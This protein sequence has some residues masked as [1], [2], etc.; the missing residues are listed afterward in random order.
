MAKLTK[1]QLK[2]IIKE[3]LDGIVK[4][5][6]IGGW[7]T[8]NVGLYERHK[9]EVEYHA[10]HIQKK[11]EDFDPDEFNVGKKVERLVQYIGEEI[12]KLRAR[13]EKATGGHAGA[14]SSSQI[15]E[16][17]AMLGGGSGDW[18]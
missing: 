9:K 8:G 4:E 7:G 13:V 1:S 3:E 5:W 16:L 12:P 15:K 2:Q 10:D 11:L 18:P 17:T 14:L 6:T